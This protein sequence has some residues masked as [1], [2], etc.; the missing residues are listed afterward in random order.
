[1]PATLTSPNIN[2]YYVGKGVVDFSTDGGSTWIDLG[3]CPKFTF[4][5]KATKLDHFTSRKGTRIKDDSIITT[6]EGTLNVVLDEWTPNNIEMAVLGE[7]ISGGESIE[8]F[9]KTQGISGILRFT[10]TNDVGPKLV[11]K[12]F[13]VRFIPQKELSLIG[14]Q[15]GQLDLD[16]EVLLDSNS[17]R[18]GF[19]EWTHG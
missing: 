14:D 7:I 10:G 13:N 6:V 11:V 8:V 15:W 2:N 3:N 18:W 1:M 17:Q 4:N 16:A 5:P 9:H 19:V 12:F